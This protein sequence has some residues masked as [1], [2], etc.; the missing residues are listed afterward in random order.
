MLCLAGLL[1]RVHHL[2]NTSMLRNKY[3]LIALAFF[4]PSVQAQHPFKYDNTVYQ[5]VYLKEAFRLM[6]SM[7][8]YLLLD[9]RSPGEYADTSRYTALNIGRIRG[10]V[11]ISIDSVSAHL[12]EL[13]KYAGQPVFVYCSHSQRSRRVSKLLA[14]NGFKKVYN[15]NGG[16]TL[17][18]ESNANDFPYKNKM[19]VTSLAYKNVNSFDAS[20]LIRDT[21]DLVIIDIRTGSE[22]ES[23]DSSQ[24]H[25]IGRL[26]NAINMPQS[27][28]AQ[29][30]DENKIPDNKPV[31]L[32]DQHGINSMD[33]VEMLRAKGFTR[34]YN[35][36]GGLEGLMNDH[37]LSQDY[38]NTL[39]TDAPPY[40]MIDPE[41]CIQL[42][43]KQKGLVIL[44]ARP[45][46]E[47]DN[48]AGM[49][50]ANLGR[51]RGA[52]HITSVVS[53]ESV[54]QHKDTS[55]QFLIYDSG[56]GLGVGICRSLVKKGFSHVHYLSPDFYHF[57]WSVAN[58]V[59]CRSGKQYLINH[60]G[61]Y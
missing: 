13:K 27:V 7:Q 1:L 16:M 9:V 51:I 10:S 18:N 33:V 15:I 43:G 42:L 22:F 48:K 19:M 60:E 23:K 41:S 61:L 31:L 57:V 59:D 8:N 5:A 39:V 36:F 40:A 37:R 46:D 26:K 3:L 58:V 44:D 52:V 45:D 34:I 21:P 24:Q 55:T 53:M 4:A 14:E 28:F 17:V 2:K 29:K 30:L 35:L 54:V 25:N 50:H 56:S 32:Y 12:P 6:D 49:S 38:L 20:Q 47:F 11:N